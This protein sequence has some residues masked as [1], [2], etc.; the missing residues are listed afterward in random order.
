MV[1]A[2]AFRVGADD[3]ALRKYI[4]NKYAPAALSAK[5]DELSLL[6]IVMTKHRFDGGS[7]KYF[8]WDLFDEHELYLPY[9][10]DTLEECLGCALEN[11]LGCLHLHGSSRMDDVVRPDLAEVDSADMLHVMGAVLHERK[12]TRSKRTRSKRPNEWPRACGGGIL[13]KFDA[14]VDAAA[15]ELVECVSDFCA[16]VCT[17]DLRGARKLL[18]RA[19]AAVKR[20]IEQGSASLETA[21]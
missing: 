21:P 14:A 19:A 10:M 3:S 1:I 13:A 17:D 16:A 2:L 9:D 7:S 8:F 6:N 18:E 4:C 15:G 11:V 20:L 12:R 5:G